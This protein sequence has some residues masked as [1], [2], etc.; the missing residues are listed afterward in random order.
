MLPATMHAGFKEAP[1]FDPIP[2]DVYQ[3]ELADITAQRVETSDWK[4]GKRDV[5]QYENIYT[6]QFVLLQGE[7]N[8]KS[9]RGLSVW[10]NYV[11]SYFYIS[12]K[13]GKNKL[14]KIVEALIG[15]ELTMDEYMTGLTGEFLNSLIGKQCRVFIEHKKSEKNGNTYANP[16]NW[17]KVTE[18]FNALTADEKE[19]A[20][21]KK[22][23]GESVQNESVPQEP[24]P[25]GKMI[26]EGDP[27]HISADS[28]P[29]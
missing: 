20:K 3:V 7:Q 6:F 16:T 27:N 4:K 19:K 28:I 8:G 25:T 1:K 9:L 12:K 26:E 17:L 13:T 15:R 10:G 18:L 14:F 23:Y 11:P 29:F 5:D 21:P 24:E 2:A 22:Q